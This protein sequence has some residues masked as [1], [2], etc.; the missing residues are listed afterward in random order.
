MCTNIWVPPFQQSQQY[1]D[2]NVKFTKF[3]QYLS[4]FLYQ[5]K[6]NKTCPLKNPLYHPAVHNHLPHP[7][8]ATW[9]ILNSKTVNPWFLLVYLVS[10]CNPIG[11]LVKSFVCEVVL[12]GLYTHTH[13]AGVIAIPCGAI[14]KLSRVSLTPANLHGHAS[15]PL[16]IG[17][18]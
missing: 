9:N 4:Y 12:A 6:H 3:S 11:W 14:S 18:Q 17:F 5:T 13:T 10:P 2:N 16:F 7:P 8:Q 1:P 15:L